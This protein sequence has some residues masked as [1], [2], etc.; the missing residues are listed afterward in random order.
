MEF[1]KNK[2]AYMLYEILE[3][4]NNLES[5]KIELKNYT[6]ECHSDESE[7]AIDTIIYAF[8]ETNI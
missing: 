8:N 3:H 2:I 1:E 4:A 5:L 6:N 7:W